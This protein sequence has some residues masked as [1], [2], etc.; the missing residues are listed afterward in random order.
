MKVCSRA[1]ASA[2]ESGARGSKVRAWRRAPWRVAWSGQHSRVPGASNRASRGGAEEHVAVVEEHLAVAVQAEGFEGVEV[3]ESVGE[4][5]V[6]V[7]QAGEPLLERGGHGL[8]AHAG[9]DGPEGVAG[10]RW[11]C[12]VED[13]E[14]A[15]EARVVL[16]EGGEED[17]CAGE[18]GFGGDGGEAEA[19]GGRSRHGSAGRG[20][21]GGGGMVAPGPLRVGLPGRAAAPAVGPMEPTAGMVPG[22][23]APEGRTG[24]QDVGLYVAF[25]LLG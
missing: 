12:V 2:G 14:V 19:G 3:F 17:E 9:G 4:G 1:G 15:V 11:E 7:A 18:E 23:G 25:S 10:V 24:R 21:G 20:A 6:D 22:T 13:D 5:R 8:E 16:E